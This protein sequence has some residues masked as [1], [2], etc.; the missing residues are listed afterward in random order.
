MGECK[1]V[2]ERRRRRSTANSQ[3]LGVAVPL[4]VVELFCVSRRFS[5][6]LFN[7][8]FIGMEY[9]QSFLGLLLIDKLS[10]NKYQHGVRTIENSFQHVL[11]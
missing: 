4:S 6:G 3:S 5:G 9:F 1:R 8:N 10:Q 2:S 11:L 7:K